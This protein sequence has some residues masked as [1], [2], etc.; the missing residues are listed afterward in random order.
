[1][2][3][4]DEPET[5][6]TAVCANCGGEFELAGL[7]RPRRFCWECAPPRLARRACGHGIVGAC[8]GC[9]RVALLTRRLPGG[10]VAGPRPSLRDAEAELT[11]R[12]DAEAASMRAR[13][14]LPA[15]LRERLLGQIEEDR[16]GWLA[17]LRE[18]YS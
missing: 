7:G 18:D 16:A 6:R 17:D 10:G 12:F 4:N 15:A 14:D 5:V 11:A 8:F 2:N 9:E 3:Q 1:M 13:D